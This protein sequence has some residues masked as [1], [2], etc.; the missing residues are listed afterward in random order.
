M[1]GARRTSPPGSALSA[2]EPGGARDA[3][4]TRG[5][6]LLAALALAFYVG[7]IAYNLWRSSAVP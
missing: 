1:T 3:R 4:I 6:W 2:D 7:Y 5:A